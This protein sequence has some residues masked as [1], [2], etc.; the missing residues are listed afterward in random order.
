MSQRSGRHFLQI[1]GP[2]NVPDRILRAIDNAVMDHRGPDFGVMARGVLDDI[3][4]VFKTESDVIIYPSSG[5]G[6]WEA[7]LVNTLSPGDRVVMYESGQF[8]TLWKALAERIGLKPQFIEGDWRHPVDPAELEAL[9][10]DDSAGDI[11]AV[12]IVHNETS[13][14]IVNDIAA[15]RRAIDSAGHSALL[16]VDTIS[17]LG[18]IDYCHDE[19]GVDVTV[20]G[21]Q[22]GLMLPP[23]LSFNA[24][25]EKAKRVSENAG[26]PKSYWSW[27]EMLKMNATGYFP[28]TPATN[29]LYGLKEAVAMLLEEGLDNVFARHARFAE[30]TRRAVRAWDLEIVCADEAAYSDVLTAVFLPEGHDADAYRKVVLENFDMSLGNGLGKVAGR[31]F[32]IGHLGDF[33]ELM[34]AGTLCGVEMGLGIAGVPHG[35]NG[36]AAALD[37]LAH[38]GN[39]APE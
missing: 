23:G 11:K 30:A 33:N 32:R 38:G 6:A 39:A 8:A 29:L 7:A 37:Y 16:M 21:S 26:I 3:K 28:Y 15:V 4:Q 27:D 20:A 31:V 2:S 1:P 14:G 12:C 18:S 5:T 10:N 17:G 35:K 19:W 25:S 34:L 13:T 9:L 22:K 24:I 36:V